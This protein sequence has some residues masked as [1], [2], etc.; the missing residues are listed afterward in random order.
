MQT[1]KSQE[2]RTD[3]NI[4]RKSTIY[5]GNFLIQEDDIYDVRVKYVK[6]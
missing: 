5:H 2:R 3:S 4:G 6:K 1:N